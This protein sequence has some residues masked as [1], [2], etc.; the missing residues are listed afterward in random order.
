MKLQ[1]TP[2]E[3][4]LKQDEDGTYSYRINGNM[5]VEGIKSER[6]ALEDAENKLMKLIRQI[7]KG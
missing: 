4:N 2:R 5:K 1:V 3:I 7:I 6:D